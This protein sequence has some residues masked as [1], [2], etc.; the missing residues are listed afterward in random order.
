MELTFKSIFKQIKYFL[1]PL[2]I[3]F[4]I[5]GIILIIFTKGSIHL[6]INSFNTP[7]MDFFFKYATNLGDGLAAA[8]IAIIV[9]YKKYK[10]AF[11]IGF[12]AILSG[13]IVQLIK[14]TLFSGAVRPSEYFKGIAELHTIPGVELYSFNSFPSG[15]SA[16]AI[17]ICLSLALLTDN[18]KLQ[19]LL[20]FMGILLAFSRVYLSQH[21]LVDIYFGAL[22]GFVTTILLWY[23]L[24]KLEN[25]AEWLAKGLKDLRKQ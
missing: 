15:H 7:I 24:S 18:K 16:T 11:L 25:K 20:S 21:F 6:A 2:I 19:V 13:F 10:G 14:R 23:Y 22:I 12:G 4:I 9:L 17:C 5:S 3:F 8:I 1:I